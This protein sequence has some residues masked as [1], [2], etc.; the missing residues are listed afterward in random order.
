MVF[1]FVMYIHFFVLILCLH[2]HLGFSVCVIVS[3][4]HS[5]K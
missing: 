1:P 5:L 4:V 3:V 2:F